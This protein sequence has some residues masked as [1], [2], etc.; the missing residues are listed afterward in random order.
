MFHKCKNLPESYYQLPDPHIINSEQ[1]DQTLELFFAQTKADIYTGTQASYN[2]T[3]DNIQMPPFECFEKATDYYAVLAHELTH[4]TKHPKR[5][6]RDFGRKQYGDPGYAEE[7]LVAEIGSCMLAADLGFEPI[8]Q[9][10]HAAYIQSW[11]KKLNN[12]KKF[13]FSAAAHAQKAVEFIHSLQPAK[14]LVI[15]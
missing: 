14:S 4:W 2:S 10:Q 15:T 7:E 13:I 12:D 11:I 3:K 9:E 8:P 5:L 1:Q 6:D